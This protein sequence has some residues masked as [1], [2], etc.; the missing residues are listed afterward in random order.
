M[1]RQLGVRYHD[2]RATPTTTIS[3]SYYVLECITANPLRNYVWTFDRVIADRGWGAFLVKVPTD[4]VVS[5]LFIE[6]SALVQV[7]AIHSGMAVERAGLLSRQ[8]QPEEVYSQ[9]VRCLDESGQ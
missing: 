3:E 4:D 5:R 8:A 7:V 2:Y 9:N 6:S 1:A